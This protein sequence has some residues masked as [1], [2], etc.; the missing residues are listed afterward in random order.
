[1][2]Y[3][4]VCITICQATALYLCIIDSIV[5][6]AVK[7]IETALW[8]SALPGQHVAVLISIL[9]VAAT[10]GWLNWVPNLPADT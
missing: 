7:M 10:H 2:L 8:L 9:N 5:F 3:S 4:N 1:M 6:A